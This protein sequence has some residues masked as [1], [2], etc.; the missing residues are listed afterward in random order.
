MSET[1]GEDVGYRPTGCLYVADTDAQEADFRAW[2]EHAK[3][4]QLDSRMI[5]RAEIDAL[6]PGA[7][8]RFSRALYTASD[9]RAEPTRAAPAM[10]RAAQR[11]GVHILTNCAVRGLDFHAGFGRCR[12]RRDRH[13]RGGGRRRRVVGTVL[14]AP[15]PRPAAGGNRILGHAHR[16]GAGGVRRRP[17]DARLRLPSP[18]DGGYTIANGGSSLCPLTPRNFRHMGKFWKNYLKERKRLRLHFGK[19]FFEDMATP[20]DWPLTAPSPF[21]K[22]RVLD[23]QPHAPLLDAALANIQAAFP[24]LKNIEIVERWAGRIDV[25]PDA[26]P[27]IGPAPDIPGFYVA[28]GFS[29]HGFG[30]GPGAGRLVA[31]LVAG[32]SPIV[33][34]TP[35]RFERFH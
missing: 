34:P 14:R 12:T 4:H 24:D 2:L 16:A 30:I 25:T 29:G 3:I 10:A 28:S 32:D 20:R 17:V 27:V 7:N 15:W 19:R 23:P 33:D 9:G 8:G 22:T 6:I 1:L 26:V 13:P 5:G 18:A 21:E 31:D 35:F 11:M